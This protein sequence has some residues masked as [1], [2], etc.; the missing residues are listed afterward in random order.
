MTDD[1]VLSDRLVEASHSLRREA[2]R[3]G[4]ARTIG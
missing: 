4:P 2:R 1:L 3:S